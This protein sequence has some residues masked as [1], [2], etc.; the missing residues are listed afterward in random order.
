M[1][2]SCYCFISLLMAMD[3][4]AMD[5]SIVGKR[6]DPLKV[7]I[8]PS[9]LQTKDS[10][11][12]ER[13]YG[14]PALEIEVL[15][16]RAHGEKLPQKASK[17]STQ[18]KN[19]TTLFENPFSMERVSWPGDNSL[20]R[21]RLGVIHDSN[22]FGYGDRSRL[23]TNLDDERIEFDFSMGKKFGEK[24]RISYHLTTQT[25]QENSG[26]NLIGNEL[27]YLHTH[28]RGQSYWMFPLGVQQFHQGGRSLYRGWDFNPVL[29]HQHRMGREAWLWMTALTITDR[30][31]D[32]LRFN[33]FD[34]QRFSLQ[35]KEIWLSR[36][37]RELGFKAS[38]ESDNLLDSSQES[39]D[40]IFGV[41]P[42]G[43][44]VWEGWSYRGRLDWTWRNNRS[45]LLADTSKRKD[46]G[47][48]VGVELK[49]PIEDWEINFGYQYRD[50][51]SNLSRYAY[52]QGLFFV[53]MNWR[54]RD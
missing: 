17:K 54:G 16:E 39:R 14:T 43:P 24:H 4:M 29:F 2:R 49:A 34:G 1:L 36:D 6:L 32:E 28:K 33:G 47:F 52:T 15:G 31:F 22:I 10:R 48:L 9:L 53:N 44:F 11:T 21:F 38:V 46:N 30:R 50:N 7:E 23:P 5:F 41:E 25:Y 45:V 13:H 8:L 40:I 3:L 27:R 35:M 42:S 19:E 26:L 18:H 51:N 20:G 37:S 12:G